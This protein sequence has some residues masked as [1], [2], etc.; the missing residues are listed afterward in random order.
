MAGA[1]E[2]FLGVYDLREILVGGDVYGIGGIGGGCPA[3]GYVEILHGAAVGWSDQR[4]GG[5]GTE[6]GGSG[7]NGQRNSLGFQ[8]MFLLSAF[9]TRIDW[10]MG[11]LF[12]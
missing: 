10:K 12:L 4:D 9:L 1:G 7:G 2:A 11:L 5:L 6:Y 3:E 8:R